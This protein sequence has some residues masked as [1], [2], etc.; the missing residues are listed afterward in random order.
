MINRELALRNFAKNNELIIF[1]A[2]KNSSNWKVLFEICKSENLNTIFIENIEELTEEW[3]RYK[4]I[5]ITGATSTPMWVLEQTK[6]DLIKN[7]V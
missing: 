7:S 1:V 6:N 4:N 2:G 5:G 3:K